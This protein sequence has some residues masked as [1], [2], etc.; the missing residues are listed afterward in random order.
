MTPP[1]FLCFGRSVLYDIKFGIFISASLISSVR[2][3]SVREIIKAFSVCAISVSSFILPQNLYGK[4]PAIFKEIILYR[5]LALLSPVVAGVLA[6]GG[7]GLTATVLFS[8]FAVFVADLV[9]FA[10]LV[11]VKKTQFVVFQYGV[12]VHLPMHCVVE[13]LVVVVWVPV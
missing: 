7:P 1:F 8:A 9:A 2:C 6:V 5:E 4:R 10:A 11:G 3:V 12:V 13:G